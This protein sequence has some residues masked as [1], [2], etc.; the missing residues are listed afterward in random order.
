MEDTYPKQDI[1]LIVKDLNALLLL[2]KY[3]R[4]LNFYKY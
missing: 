2:N 4:I 1:L 3:W